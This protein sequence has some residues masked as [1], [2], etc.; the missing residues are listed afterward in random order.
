MMDENRRLV[1]HGS[2]PINGVVVALAGLLVVLGS[3]SIV[4]AAKPAPET[5]LLVKQVMASNPE[6]KAIDR[7]IEAL[8][9]KADVVQMWMD[10]VFMVEY[11]NFPWN[12]WSLGDSPMTGVQFRIQQTFPLIGK[13]S[14]REATVRAESETAGWSLAEKR[15]KLAAE[16][17]KGY[18][19]LALVRQLREVTARHVSLVGQLIDAVRAKYQVGKVGQ[20]DL[21]KLEVLKEKL[22]DDLNDFA[23]MEREIAANLNA[24][25]HREPTSAIETPGGL[26]AEPLSERTIDEW[27][28]IA[29]QNN[30]LLKVFK[31]QA[32][33]KRLAA[34][35][36]AYERWPDITLWAGYRIRRQA[37]MDD[38]TDQMTLGVS[39][40]LP[41]DYTG[42][43]G[44]Q[45]AAHLSE[46][47]SIE[48][49]EAA[50]LDRVASMIAST[51]AKWE[52]AYQKSQT[53]GNT[54]IPDSQRT[55]DS[56]LVSYQSD[57]ADFL[58][59]YQAELQLLDFERSLLTAISQTHIQRATLDE[60]AGLA[61]P[62]D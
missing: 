29:K 24:L 14:R 9:H 35:Q 49:H 46:A 1:A 8:R 11:G 31:T 5:E 10:P 56:T 48:E 53:Y 50:A 2:R 28:E 41:F 55:L 3:I 36:A 43:Y 20:H 60:L 25:L 26:D 58:S 22:K 62:Q 44:A 42:R 54:L 30:P 7:Q 59:L 33:A 57:R 4:R 15:N 45:R 37:G 23:S 27:I 38:G 32:R 16:V 39:I 6:L 19:N 12:T 13:N 18:W 47:S 61:A 40:P 34:D 51:L 21:M 52:R 17:R